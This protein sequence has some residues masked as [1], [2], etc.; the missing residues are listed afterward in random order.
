[1]RHLLGVVG[2]AVGRSTQHKLRSLSVWEA[3]FGEAQVELLSGIGLCER[4]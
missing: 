2:G 3:P 1:M 4:W